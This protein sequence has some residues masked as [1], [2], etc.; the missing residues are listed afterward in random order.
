M[1]HRKL[2]LGGFE[3]CAVPQRRVFPNGRSMISPQNFKSF[4]LLLNSD[5][6]DQLHATKTAQQTVASENASDNCEEDKCEEDRE[7]V[8]QRKRQKGTILFKKRDRDRLF[9][10]RKRNFPPDLSHDDERDLTSHIIIRSWF[11]N[12]ASSPCHHRRL[13][14]LWRN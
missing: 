12:I 5:L 4:V 2:R 3:E 1:R 8:S 11:A 6:F 7:R 10:T 13:I 14:F 9:S